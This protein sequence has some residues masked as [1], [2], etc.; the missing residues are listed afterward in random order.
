MDDSKR[1]LLSF[2]RSDV[3]REFLQGPD[4][5]QIALH[6]IVDWSIVLSCV[7]LIFNTDPILYPIWIILI[8]GRMHAF[9]VLLHDL[10]HLNPKK[11]P[12]SFRILEVLVGY[13]IGTTINAMAYHHLRH[14]RD[15]LMNSDPYY[16]INK[17]CSTPKRLMLTI[18][19]GSVFVLFWC[20]RSLIGTFAYYIPSLRTQY[21]RIFL[22]DVSGQDLSAHE[23][24]IRCAKEDRYL[25]AFQLGVLTLALTI[26]P[27]LFYTYY[28]AWPVAGI[29]CIYRLLIEHVYD[30]V[31][32]RSVYTMIESTFD[33]HISLVD[34][35]L[36]GPRNIG[37]HCM[38]HIHPQVGFHNLPQLREWYLANCK[39]YNDKYGEELIEE[40]NE[41]INTN[42]L[43]VVYP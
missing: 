25:L 13:P 26:M 37:Y 18:G 21:A 4:L 12:I 2:K 5:V 19:K 15:T 43:E 24:V 22:Q 1:E 27:S 31:E 29:F 41:E 6:T 9:G 38:H 39:Q 35:I 10:S 16:K 42:G 8:A 30:V 23:E 3:P 36:I 7:Y 28:I 33:H 20:T 11:K 40:T 34:Q 17:K 32:D 14:H